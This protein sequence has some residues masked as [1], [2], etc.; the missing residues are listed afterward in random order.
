MTCTLNEPV[1]TERI[2]RV[3]KRRMMKMSDSN[4]IPRSISA[5]IIV[6]IQVKRR[7]ESWKVKSV[8]GE[9]DFD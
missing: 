8:R 3:S 4:E 5:G 2:E 1:G 7:G 6:N 9:R